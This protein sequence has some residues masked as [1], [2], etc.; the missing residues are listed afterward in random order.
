ME[1]VQGILLRIEEKAR[2]RNMWYPNGRKWIIDEDS[3][4]LNQCLQNFAKNHMYYLHQSL[5][6]EKMCEGSF[7]DTLALMDWHV[8]RNLEV[9][10]SD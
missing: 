10:R 5:I 9:F 8:R 4:N 6:F 7:Q 3:A 2:D 1:R